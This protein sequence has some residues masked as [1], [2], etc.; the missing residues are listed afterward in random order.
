MELLCKEDRLGNIF[1]VWIGKTCDW[2]LL[3]RK[4]EKS[5]VVLSVTLQV[6]MR[7]SGGC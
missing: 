7:I 5:I 6:I 2:D 3:Y 4:F 1:I